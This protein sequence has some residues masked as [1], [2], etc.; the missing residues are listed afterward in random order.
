MWAAGCVFVEM[1]LGK[2]LF[3]GRHEIDQ[4]EQILDSVCL[5]EEEWIALKPHLPDRTAMKRTQEQGSA[6]GS[7][8][9]HIDIQG[10]AGFV[11]GSNHVNIE[12]NLHTCAMVNYTYVT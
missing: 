1:L 7:K 9:P 5:T 8:F 4:M 10:K 2:P 3:E 11:V 12:I 6:L